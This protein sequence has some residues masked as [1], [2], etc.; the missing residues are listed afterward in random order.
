MNDNNKSSDKNSQFRTDSSK[1]IDFSLKPEIKNTS[2]S[3]DK[4]KDVSKPQPI[5]KESIKS[6]K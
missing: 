5:S 6:E 2:L 1:T 3:V 4:I